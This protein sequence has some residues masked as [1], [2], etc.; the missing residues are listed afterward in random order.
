[1]RNLNNS[2]ARAA[3]LS[4]L[5]L[6][7]SLVG[8]QSARAQESDMLQNW[9]MTDCEVGQEGL[10][11]SEL[12]LLGPQAVP[13]LLVAAKS[14]P[15]PTLIAEREASL[16]TAFD[17]IQKDL[18]ISPPA[19][20]DPNDVKVAQSQ[21]L[22]DFIAEDINGFILTYRVRALRGLGI[23]GGH[24][25]VQ[26]LQQ[27]ANDASSPALQASAKDALAGMFSR[28]SVEL[29]TIGEAQPGFEMKGKF[30]LAKNSGG[31]DPVTETVI[32][33]AGPFFRLIPLG[34]F[35]KTKIDTYVFEGT[36]NS[37]KMHFEIRVDGKD[38]YSF[39]LRARGIDVSPLTKST[40]VSL[41]IGNNSGLT[42]AKVE[43][44]E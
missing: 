20:L 2:F 6:A 39:S 15:D 18:V 44:G 42:T 16:A 19:G 22:E 26:A 11:Y 28:F 8:V 3:E 1:M 5:V 14:G 41:A 4:T 37:V 24:L 13:V 12:V 33:Q 35:R 34:S 7:L 23:V 9:L 21:T 43:T 30:R 38:G 36:V 17:A 10:A 25:A 27:F 32:V 31:V 40:P 29:E